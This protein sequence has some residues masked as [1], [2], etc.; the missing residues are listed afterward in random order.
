MIHAHP[1][2]EYNGKY[3][4]QDGTKNGQLWFRNPSAKVLYYYGGPSLPNRPSWN[5]DNR[6]ALRTY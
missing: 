2:A 6:C 1:I 5:L 4:L 3:V